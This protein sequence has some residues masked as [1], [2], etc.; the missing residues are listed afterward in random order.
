MRGLPLLRRFHKL[1]PRE[2]QTTVPLDRVRAVAETL[3]PSAY[4]SVGKL[5][6]RQ[7]RQPVHKPAIA[8]LCSG[9]QVPVV[10]RNITHTGCRIEF[11]KKIQT[12]GRLLLKEQSLALETWASVV[13]SAEGAC[14]LLFEDSERLLETV[15]FETTVLPS[16][17]APP[18]PARPKG[19]VRSSLRKR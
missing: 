14:G 12:A 4:T 6:K 17:S 8:V 19:R 3:A 1:D 10:I 13:W 9:E 2:Q 16:P 11:H 7:P 5:N 18:I 15:T